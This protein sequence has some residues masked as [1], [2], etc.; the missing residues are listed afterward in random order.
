MT[1]AIVQELVEDRRQGIWMFYRTT[2]AG[3]PFLREFLCALPGRLA[4]TPQG[5]D[6]RRALRAHLDKK[7]E[8]SCA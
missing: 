2:T 6:D 7:D 3:E 4:K 5:H 8:T 1:L